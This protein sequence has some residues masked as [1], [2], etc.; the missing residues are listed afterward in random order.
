MDLRRRLPECEGW[1]RGHVVKL[2]DWR[3]LNTFRLALA[4][5]EEASPPAQSTGL[6][7]CSAVQTD[8]QSCELPLRGLACLPSF[9]PEVIGDDR[10]LPVTQ[11]CPVQPSRQALI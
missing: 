8:I 3:E 6:P 9:L 2:P 10:G 7:Q 4:P 1:V 11:E 5:A